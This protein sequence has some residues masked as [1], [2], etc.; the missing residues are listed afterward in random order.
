M[1]PSVKFVHASMVHFPKK[2]WVDCFLEK[3]Q[4]GGGGGGIRGGFG[5]IPHFFRFFSSA[6]LPYQFVTTL[7]LD[8]QTSM[9]TLPLKIMCIS[10]VAAGPDHLIKTPNIESSGATW[11]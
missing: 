5:K 3:D 4:T 11:H 1:G 6:P 8:I 9:Y 2:S 10:W 7:L